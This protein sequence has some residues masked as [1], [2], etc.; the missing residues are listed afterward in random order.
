MLFVFNKIQQPHLFPR[1]EKKLRLNII[2]LK[3]RKHGGAEYHNKISFVQFL[4]R[5]WGRLASLF[6]D[7]DLG[8]AFL[9]FRPE[10][11]VE[12]VLLLHP[13]LYKI[14]IFHQEF[15]GFWEVRPVAAGPMW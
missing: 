13:H 2:L 14:H 3:T 8:G 7:V 10:A 5:E 6:T 4:T 11:L 1:R 15:G 9:G 12:N